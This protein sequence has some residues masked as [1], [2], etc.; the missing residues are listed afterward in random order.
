MEKRKRI[1]SQKELK[2]KKA[3][4]EKLKLIFESE[5]KND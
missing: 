1:K 3:E 5:N 4:Y 2:E